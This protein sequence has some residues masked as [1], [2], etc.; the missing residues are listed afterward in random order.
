MPKGTGYKLITAHWL[1]LLA[2]ILGAAACGEEPQNTPQTAEPPLLSRAR[3]QLAELHG[4]DQRCLVL[5]RLAKQTE[6]FFP[7]LSTDFFQK[8]LKSAQQAGGLKFQQTADRLRQKAKEAPAPKNHQLLALARRLE[9]AAHT[10][11]RFRLVAKG[12]AI[13]QPGLAQQALELALLQARH[14]PDLAA[15]DWELASLIVTMVRRDQAASLALV[16]K[17]GQPRVRSWVN[18]LLAR[19]LQNPAFLLQ[20]RKDAAQIK[21]PAVRAMVL[22]QIGGRLWRL[23]AQGG[24]HVF[25]EA[26]KAAKLVKPSERA[27]MVR[28]ESAARFLAPT[29]PLML[30]RVWE[31]SPGK[32]ARFKA[33]HQAARSL[34][35]T[36]PSRGRQVW[37]AALTEASGLE[38]NSERAT[39]LALLVRDMA[40]LDPDEAVRALKAAPQG[41]GAALFRQEAEAA[42]ALAEAGRDI[43]MAVVKATRISD[44]VLSFI[45]LARLALVQ[46]R[47]DQAAGREVYAKML[48]MANRLGYDLFPP[49]ILARAAHMVRPGAARRLARRF[50]DKYLQARYLFN[51][52]KIFTKNKN[53]VEGRKS[54]QIS[55]T[56]LKSPDRKLILDKLRLLGDMGLGWVKNDVEQA[57]EIFKLAAALAR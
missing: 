37:Q 36:E 50:K 19:E 25:G 30:S 28:G 29:S 2:L 24:D 35:A 23:K 33:L 40:A 31:L 11:W 22:S 39:A 44:P 8:L 1:L 15:R 4:L 10:S 51:L 48:D 27:R 47:R 56:T 42:L 21:D 34:L 16:N 7:K 54:L 52:A 3:A 26:L 9:R 53:I 55:L 46:K 18:R 32:G 45:T 20:A 12:A 6:T 14:N 13:L 49:E 38:L 17:I 43:E 41:G 5:W 57:R